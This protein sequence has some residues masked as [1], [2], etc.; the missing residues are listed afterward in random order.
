MKTLLNLSLLLAVLFSTASTCSNQDTTPAL[1]LVF[2]F[3]LLND[4]GDVSTTFAE[5]EDIALQLSVTNSTSQRVSL[6]N[7][8]SIF[9]TP[10]SETFWIDQKILKE[11]STSET[12]VRLGRACFPAIT[13]NDGRIAI[14]PNSTYKLSMKWLDARPGCQANN[15][16][17]KKGEY[18][19]GFTEE[20]TGNGGEYDGQSVTPM[21]IV[22]FE[23]K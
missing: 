19:A 3:E 16:P 18:R 12:W 23:V 4:K 10:T 17:L 2:K 14:G 11:N 21:F 8:Y 7:F 13:Y 22:P 15:Q 20:F 5:G 6:Y 9:G 1:P